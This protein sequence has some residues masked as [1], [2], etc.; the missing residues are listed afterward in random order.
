MSP[1]LVIAGRT[2]ADALRG[3]AGLFQATLFGVLTL[4]ISY[5]GLAAGG[6]LGFQ[7]LNRTAL[8]LVS[9][10]LYLVPLVALVQGAGALSERGSWMEILMSQPV[11][12]G[13]IVV[14]EFL[15]LWLAVGGAVAGGVATGS[16]WVWLRAG[17]D[18][19]A[20]GLLVALA[21]GL[22]MVFVALGLAIG[23][24]FQ[25]RVTALAAALGAWFS[26]VVLYD[27]GVMG[28]T[29][30]LQGDRLERILVL[31]AAANPVDA[32]RIVA[33]GSFVGQTLFGATGAAVESLLGPAGRLALVAV[34]G[35]WTIGSLV[36]AMALFHRREA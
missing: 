24:A 18:P 36:A 7:A 31:A 28:L 25:R 33:L 27:L 14:G 2:C 21:L 4:L 30:V 17:G 1:V 26:F 11:S 12:R 5:V 19:S 10:L 32:A 34:M 35:L 23:A 8:S 29:A 16:A 9:L 13:Q 6:I 20:L 15:G 22:S 3:R